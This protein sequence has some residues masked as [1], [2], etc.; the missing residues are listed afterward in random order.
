[1]NRQQ[2]IDSGYYTGLEIL[3]LQACE[4]EPKAIWEC[5]KQIMQER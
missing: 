3:K 5:V 1:M 4:D 2:L